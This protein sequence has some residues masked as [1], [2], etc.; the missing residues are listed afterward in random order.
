MKSVLKSKYSVL[1]SLDER[2]IEE[3]RPAL[4]QEQINKR[5]EHLGLALPESYK[6]FLLHCSGFCL[7]GGAVQLGSQ[8]PFFHDFPKLD[9]LTQQQRRV[10]RQRGGSWP[11]PS[12]GM[13]CFAEYFLLAD[14]DQIL[15]KIDEGLINGEYPVYYYAHE[16]SP[17]RVLK[18][19]DSFAQWLNNYCV[20][21]MQS[22]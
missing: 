14:G 8:H 2:D 4:S 15:F 20:Q 13:L 6:D 17:A 1:S 18:I 19:A 11:P 3:I 10:V 16:E 22:T 9:D 12:N 5:E 7:F 21:Q